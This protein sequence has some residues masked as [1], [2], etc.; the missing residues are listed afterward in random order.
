MEPFG[1]PNVSPVPEQEL[2]SITGTPGDLRP[3]TRAKD[4]KLSGGS[5]KDGD[6]CNHGG[7]GCNDLV[8]W[9]MVAWHQD[10]MI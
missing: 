8:A 6:S 4:F 3:R 5:C 10:A 7:V 1:K 9:N 2:I